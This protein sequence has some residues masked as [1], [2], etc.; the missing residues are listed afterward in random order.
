MNTWLDCS[1]PML[2]SP[3]PNTK[4]YHFYTYLRFPYYISVTNLLLLG[5]IF[6]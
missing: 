4:V 6:I 5:T 2:I 1:I 3:V